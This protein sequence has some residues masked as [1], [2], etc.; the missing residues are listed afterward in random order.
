[1]MRFSGNMGAACI[2]GE[3]GL[4]NIS[5][6][7]INTEDEEMSLVKSKEGMEEREY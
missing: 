4:S 7:K 2:R 3:K 5:E 1:M 6:G